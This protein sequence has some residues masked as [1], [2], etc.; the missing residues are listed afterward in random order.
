MY[1]LIIFLQRLVPHIHYISGSRLGSL[2]ICISCQFFIK[3]LLREC[4]ILVKQLLIDIEWHRKYV[5][6]HFLSFCL[7]NSTVT[8]CYNRNF[9]HA[10]FTSF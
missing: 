8:I 4:D 10:L 6:S 2:N 9:P 1:N 3:L 7:C 5:N